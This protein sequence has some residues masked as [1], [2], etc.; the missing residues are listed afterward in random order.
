MRYKLGHWAIKSIKT[1]KIAEIEG[2]CLHIKPEID[3]RIYMHNRYPSPKERT[4]Q[5]Q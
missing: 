1:R 3:L 4:T 2:Y 5:V